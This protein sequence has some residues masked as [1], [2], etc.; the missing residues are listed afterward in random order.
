M[1]AHWRAEGNSMRDMLHWEAL[2]VVPSEMQKT[3]RSLS[4]SEESLGPGTVVESPEELRFLVCEPTVLIR[5][6]AFEEVRVSMIPIRR[7]RRPGQRI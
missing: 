2:I 5:G 7:W 1:N 3:W 4:L 6:G